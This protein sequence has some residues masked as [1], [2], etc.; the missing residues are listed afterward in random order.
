LRQEDNNFK[1]NFS[2]VY[3]DTQGDS[4]S[5]NK[6]K[7]LKARKRLFPDT[8]LKEFITTTSKLRAGSWHKW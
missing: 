1:F 5:K 4:A 3:I 6:N 7:K 2:L 8:K